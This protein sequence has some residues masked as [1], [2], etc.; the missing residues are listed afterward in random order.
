MILNVALIAMVIFLATVL[1]KKYYLKKEN[2]VIPDNY[3]AKYND[4]THQIDVR[5]LKASIDNGNQYTIVDL[6]DRDLYSQEHIP[7]AINIPVDELE[8]R[9]MD[10]L[11]LQNVI[12]LY[13]RC[14]SDS[15]SYTGLDILNDT[16]SNAVVLKGGIKDW[17]KVGFPTSNNFSTE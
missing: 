9:M 1:G 10:E 7:G 2:I 6:D 13:C 14:D 3:I 16:F 11:S 5:A 15:R 12:V 8:T 4:K 17:K